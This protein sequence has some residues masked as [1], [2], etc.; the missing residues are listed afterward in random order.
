[1]SRSLSLRSNAPDHLNAI[2]VQMSKIAHLRLDAFCPQIPDGFRVELHQ[3]VL[4]H[5]PTENET[6]LRIVI[7]Q[8]GDFVGERIV[9]MLQIGV[10]PQT[11]DIDAL[12][13][14]Q[15]GLFGVGF[16]DDQLILVGENEETST[17]GV[18]TEDRHTGPQVTGIED[19]DRCQATRDVDLLADHVETRSFVST[20]VSADRPRFACR[21]LR[22]ARDFLP[23]V[24]VWGRRGGV[25]VHARTWTKSKKKKQ[26]I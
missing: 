21:W 19:A 4:R 5:W 12:L 15:R 3:E 16:A 14:F 18:I 25:S 8:R 6:P 13:D 7:G 24:I 26:I 11:M 9:R 20:K 23:S 10:Q 17:G 1:M 22:S 2:E